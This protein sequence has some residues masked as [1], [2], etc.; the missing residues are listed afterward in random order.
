M[1]TNTCQDP[2]GWTPFLQ[3]N[4]MKRSIVRSARRNFSRQRAIGMMKKPVR[5]PVIS[6]AAAV[7]RGIG[8]RRGGADGGQFQQGGGGRPRRHRRVLR[9][10]IRVYR[11]CVFFVKCI[12]SFLLQLMVLSSCFWW[13]MEIWVLRQRW[14]RKRSCFGCVGCGEW[15]MLLHLFFE[16]DIWSVGVFVQVWAL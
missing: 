10:L 3:Q 14:M 6:A 15:S 16:S 8:R 2:I 1:S 11:F 4:Q 12:C 9:L 7:G 5:I 13:N